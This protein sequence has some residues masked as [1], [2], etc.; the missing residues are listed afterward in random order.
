MLL[1]TLNFSVQLQVP[2]PYGNQCKPRLMVLA[3]QTELREIQSL[4]KAFLLRRNKTENNRKT[5]KR[6]EKESI[7]CLEKRHQKTDKANPP[8]PPPPNLG[9][10]KLHFTLQYNKKVVKT[11]QT[12]QMKNSYKQPPQKKG[13]KYR[14]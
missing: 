6:K 1:L 8:P 14:V 5:Q 12:Q 9:S 13:D 11:V 7:I 2:E 3:N 4:S 10:R